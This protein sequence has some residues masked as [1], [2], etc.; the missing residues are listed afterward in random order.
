MIEAIKDYVLMICITGLI[1]GIIISLSPNS[2]IEKTIKLVASIFFV[3]VV[4]TPFFSGKFNVSQK[5]MEKYFSNNRVNSSSY[6]E[7][8]KKS[9]ISASEKALNEQILNTLQDNGLE[10]K[11]VTCEIKENNN[12]YELN[13]IVLDLSKHSKSNAIN[14]LKNKFNI[15]PEVIFLKSGE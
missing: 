6:N 7:N 4:I 15:K 2:S 8:F 13:K 9:A 10:I 14:I 12:T 1:S 11:E 5:E 3:S